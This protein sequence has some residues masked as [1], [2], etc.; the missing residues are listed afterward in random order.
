VAVSGV[1]VPFGLGFALL[2]ALGHG[3]H[4]AL[5]VGAALVA[6]S[7]SVAARVLG[8]L[9]RLRDRESQTILS[10]AVIDD[11]LGLVVLAVVAGTARGHLSVRSL[12][13]LLVEVAVF[14]AAITT[15]GRRLFR[16]I[17][18]SLSRL[19]LDEGPFVVGVAVCLGLAE[20]AR[21]VGLA[22]TVGAFLA[23]MLFAEVRDSYDIRERI[24]P[25]TNFLAPFFFVVTGMAVVPRTFTDTA[26]LGLLAVVFA[27]AVLGKLVPA[28][29]AARGFGRR[30]ALIVGAGMVPRAEVGIIVASLGLTSGV[31][32]QRLY[33]VVLAMSALT[34]MVAPPALRALFA[35]KR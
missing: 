1:V 6:S 3:E 4:E 28:A 17:G 29:V 13:V 5:F 33:S 19:R 11:V 25:V 16:W 7:A 15:L 2:A 20:L 30:G 14:F 18:P 9:G 8:D 26:A 24:R 35:G 21:A 34:W 31:I 27:I 23:G 22:G 10:A 12:V 32:G